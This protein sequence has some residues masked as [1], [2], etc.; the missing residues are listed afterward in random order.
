MNRLL[1]VLS[2]L[3]LCAL[4]LTLH[5]CS[6]DSQ[7]KTKDGKESVA[8][9]PVEV[10]NAA[11][12]DIAAYFTGTATLEAEAEAV[13]VAKVAGVVQNILVEEGF[14]VRR[15][16]VLARLE[17]ERPALQAAQAEANLRKLENDYRRNEELFS[18]NLISAEI[19][20][21]S[22][23]EYESQKAAYEMAKLELDYTSIRAPI[24][25]V[26]SQRLIKA[27]NMMV[28]NAPTFRVTDFDPLLA[29][30]HVPEREMGKLRVGQPAT[31]M[32][33]AIAGAE[34]SGRVA[35]ISPVVDAST[36]TIKVTVEVRDALQRLKPGMFG[37]INIV[38]DVHTN[39]T[40]VPKDAVLS[41]DS[42]SAIFVVQDSMAFRKVVKTG[43]INGARVE[44]LEGLQ[45][46]QTIVTTGHGSLKDS[47]KV[48]VISQ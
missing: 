31:L 36:G 5:G 9:I 1:R 42:E 8:A 29:V 32:V 11:K 19:H 13:V 28:A 16:Q 35:R 21:R 2:F 4:A 15:G 41:E 34:F 22:K 23:F 47:A 6:K 37:R 27:G 10:A 44:I 17:Q 43:Y 38:Y 12:G 40:L 20:Q 25:G 45:P 7:S 33:D 30:L 39:A 46:G 24:D 14:S 48:E 26:V 18:K 3:S